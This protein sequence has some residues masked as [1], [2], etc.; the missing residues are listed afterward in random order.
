[1]RSSN[2]TASPVASAIAIATAVLVVGV[3]YGLTALA[4]GFPPWLVILAAI[5]VLSASSELLFVGVIAAGGLPGVAVA[6]ALLVNLRNIVYG[7]SAS[8]FLPTPR[9]AR[10]LTAHLVN[11]E[12]VAFA[13]TQQKP[14]Q[15]LAAFRMVGVAILIAW[16]VGAAIG[17]LVGYVVPDPA[18]LGLDAAFPAIFV[19]ILSGCI[20]RSALAPAAAGAT[21][22]AALT[23]FVATGLAPIL[24][25]AGLLTSVRKRKNRA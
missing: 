17:V 23:P 16:P 11:D 9:I 13:L 12:T 15:R 18:H 21:I 5:L 4:A 1:M 19:A 6:A 3:A 7:I 14:A 25:L 20:R 22:A 24:G 2:R 10:Y 8:S